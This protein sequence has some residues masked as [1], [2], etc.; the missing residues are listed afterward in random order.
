MA[1]VI[2]TVKDPEG[3]EI[4]SHDVQ[5]TITGDPLEDPPTPAQDWVRGLLAIAETMSA[6]FERRPLGD[7]HEH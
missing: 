5:V 3:A 2:L 1:T 6:A 7:N 4:L